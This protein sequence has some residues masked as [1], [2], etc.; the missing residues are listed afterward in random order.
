MNVLVTLCARS[1]ISRRACE[2][3]SGVMWVGGS[4]MDTHRSRG[5]GQAVG[6]LIGGS[7][8]GKRALEGFE[9]QNDQELI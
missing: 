1:V 5:C 6:P 9:R 4:H 7:D 2:V 8:E 3:R